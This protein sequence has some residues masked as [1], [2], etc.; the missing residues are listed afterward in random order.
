[1]IVACICGGIIEIPLAIGAF[2]LAI[3]CKCF[4]KKKETDCP[5]DCHEPQ[6][7]N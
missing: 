6:E 4:G 1:M 3:C 7:E 5:C 2:I